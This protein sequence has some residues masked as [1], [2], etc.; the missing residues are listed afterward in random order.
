MLKQKELGKERQRGEKARAEVLKNPVAWGGPG[1]YNQTSGVL[2]NGRR[3]S[4]P[5]SALAGPCVGP[6]DHVTLRLWFCA[7][8]FRWSHSASDCVLPFPG[9]RSPHWGD[10]PT[11]IPHLGPGPLEY[12]AQVVLGLPPGPTET[13]WSIFLRAGEFTVRHGDPLNGHN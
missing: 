4:T 2:S 6:W 3:G 10:R 13:T 5:S 1:N 9:A 7:P 11:W 12:P 8:C